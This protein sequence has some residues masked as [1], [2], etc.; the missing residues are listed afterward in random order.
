MQAEKQ[1]SNEEFR[2]RKPDMAREIEEK[3]AAL[4][5]KVAELKTHLKELE[6]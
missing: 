4:Q 3:L 6:S 5:A 1:L 2:K